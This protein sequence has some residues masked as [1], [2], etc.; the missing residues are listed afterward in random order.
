VAYFGESLPDCESACDHCL[1]MDL[2]AEIRPV[3]TAKPRAPRP[4][5]SGIEAADLVGGADSLALLEQLKAVRKKLADQKGVPA[6]LIFSDAVLLQMVVERPQ[7]D[8]EMLRLNG[9]GPK[10]LAAYADHFLPLLSH[11]GPEAS[12]GWRR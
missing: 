12:S 7:N 4:M 8:E 3:K 2:L 6:Y 5:I 10:K 9:V 1:K 11:A